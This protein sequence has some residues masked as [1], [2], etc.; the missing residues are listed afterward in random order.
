MWWDSSNNNLVS[1]TVEGEFDL[2]TRGGPLARFSLRIG[3][4]AAT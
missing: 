3:H 4:L 2:L 1:E